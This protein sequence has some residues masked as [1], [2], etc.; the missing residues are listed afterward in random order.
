[1]A[2]LDIVQTIFNGVSQYQVDT[3]F[4]LENAV[5]INVVQFWFRRVFLFSLLVR[6]FLT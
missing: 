1:M 6:W 4:L 2:G 3:K 5:Y